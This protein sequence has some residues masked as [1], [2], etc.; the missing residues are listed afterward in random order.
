[1]SKIRTIIYYVLSFGLL[2]FGLMSMAFEGEALRYPN[3]LQSI[4]KIAAGLALLVP[5][6]V[7]VGFT[8]WR[9]KMPLGAWLP[10]IALVLSTILFFV[11]L[12]GAEYLG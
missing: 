7:T 1:M 10:P 4:L 9:S 6:I 2:A 12:I 3:L 8:F 11:L 5:L